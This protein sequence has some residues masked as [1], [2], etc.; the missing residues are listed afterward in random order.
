MGR[1]EVVSYS[2]VISA[3]EVI[4]STQ[5]RFFYLSGISDP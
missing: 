2:T 4:W 5:A 3:C 1:T